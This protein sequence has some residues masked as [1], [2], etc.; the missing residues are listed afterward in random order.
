[1]LHILNYTHQYI[2]RKNVWV[3]RGAQQRVEPVAAPGFDHAAS[4]PDRD[5]PDLFVPARRPAEANS[6]QRLCASNFEPESSYVGRL[7]VSGADL[8]PASR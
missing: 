3:E 1:M 5:Q 7:I 2:S 6:Q 4:L 8:Q